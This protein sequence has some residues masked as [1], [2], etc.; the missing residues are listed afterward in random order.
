MGLIVKCDVC[1]R[2]DISVVYYVSE[3][4]THCLDCWVIITQAVPVFNLDAKQAELGMGQIEAEAIETTLRDIPLN[5]LHNYIKHGERMD[6]PTYDI[7]ID[8][9]IIAPEIPKAPSKRPAREYKVV[10]LDKVATK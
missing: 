4:S 10:S 7:E 1:G 8:P 6:S 5:E 9:P 3:R 2:E